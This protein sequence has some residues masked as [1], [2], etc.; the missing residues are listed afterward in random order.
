[1]KGVLAS[2]SC[3][4]NDYKYLMHY[5]QDYFS[6]YAQGYRWKWGNPEG[7]CGWTGPGHLCNSNPYDPNNP[8]NDEISWFMANQW[9]E[10]WV[11][12]IMDACAGKSGLSIC[13]CI[14]ANID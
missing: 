4:P 1:L 6:H 11:K 12:K 8:D 7:V 5:G 2:G 3:D 9:T 14:P 10:E 13:K